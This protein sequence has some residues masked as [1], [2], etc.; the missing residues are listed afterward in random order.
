VSKSLD[1]VAA[2]IP[3]FDTSE[4]NLRFHEITGLEP[5]E[6][7]MQRQFGEEVMR[8]FR[9]PPGA[10]GAKQFYKIAQASLSPWNCEEFVDLYSQMLKLIDETNPAVVVLDFAFRPAIDAT[11]KRNRLHA[12]L[13]PTAL[14]DMLP[15]IQPRINVLWKY[16]M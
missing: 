9:H 7:V 11:R 10:R 12:F 2:S 5:M 1:K 8:H 16:P 4:G 6:V 15:M 13:T 3:N 14:A